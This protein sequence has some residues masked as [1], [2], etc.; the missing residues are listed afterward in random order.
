MKKYPTPLLLVLLMLAFTAC[1]TEKPPKV[2]NTA[3]NIIII[4]A[5]DMGFSDLGCTG[6]EI[7]TP[8][9]DK[10][11][12]EGALFTNFYNTSRCC[13][14]RTSLLTGQYQWDA[15]M[16]HMT[17]PLG[18]LPEYQGYINSKSITIAEALKQKGYQTFM[19]GKWH[20]GEQRHMWPDKRGFDQFYGVPSGGGLYYYP[21]P[22]YERSVFWNGEQVHP[23]SNWYSTEG[24][25]DYTVDYIK[26]QRKKDQPFF[27]YQAY[28]AP[29][30]PLQAK[31]GDIEKY[32]N[33]YTHGYDS[34]RAARFK[35]QIALGIFPD[36]SQPSAPAYMAWN[37]LENPN[38]EAHKMTVYAAM[39]DCM[40][41]NIG[42]IMETLE[43]EG[44]AENTIICFLSDNGACS[45][46]FNETPDAEIGTRHS[47]AAYGDWYNVSNT[48][49]RKFKR[50][51][52]EGGIITPMIINWPKGI[53]NKGQLIRS[54]AHISDFMPTMLEIVGANY[55]SHYNGNKLD[56]LDG[57]SFAHLLEDSTK[58]DTTRTLFWEH[59][60]NRAVRQGYWKLVAAHNEEWELYQLKKD[61]F[62][63]ENLINTY[64]KIAS[65]LLVKY[66]TW[67][68]K[69]KVAN[70]PIEVN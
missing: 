70:W 1:K 69:H 3:P 18:N 59:E 14:S 67:A 29:H 26:N 35:K 42:R 54:P 50:E 23:D 51:E 6:S 60:G 20:V 53:K 15:G 8:N 49:Y 32:R 37:E 2:N 36:S 16:G 11:A 19:S 39:V 64:P 22:F 24:F 27:I 48:P 28:I 68:K 17:R 44:I 41:Q 7:E 12:A 40:D 5:D 9:L 25:T 31:K 4:L 58:T 46:K 55:P 65:S 57:K 10:L 13:P 52:H 38:N 56:S 30:F 66:K 47:N 62:E 61:P 34:I 45:R 21:S 63:T 43:K 33:L